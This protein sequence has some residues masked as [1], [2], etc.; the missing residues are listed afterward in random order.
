MWFALLAVV[1]GIA[2]L[3]WQSHELSSVGGKSHRP[4]RCL[5]DRWGLLW[6]VRELALLALVGVLALPARTSV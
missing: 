3:V 4:G 2:R 5:Q 6:L 1:A